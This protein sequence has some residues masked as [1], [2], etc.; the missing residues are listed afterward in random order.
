MTRQ[1]LSDGARSD[2]RA[3]D[4]TRLAVYEWGKSEGPEVLLVHGFAH[5]RARNTVGG[6]KLMLRGQAIA[7][8]QQAGFDLCTKTV[9]E[10]VGQ[11]F[12]DQ[13]SRSGHGKGWR[14]NVGMEHGYRVIIQIV[15]DF[16]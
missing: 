8:A 9:C 6:G 2:V 1:R 10:A 16:I 5:H 7:R 4:G 14:G 11:P 15:R 3:P 12:G 13:G